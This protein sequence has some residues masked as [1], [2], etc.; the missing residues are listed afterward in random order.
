MKVYAFIII[1][2]LLPLPAY[3]QEEFE[4]I[5]KNQFSILGGLS[6][7]TGDFGE[8]N[9]QKAGFAKTGFG[10]GLELDVPVDES[11][12]VV[13][14]GLFLSNPIDESAMN[15]LFQNAFGSSANVQTESFTSIFALSG[16]QFIGRSSSTSKLFLHA[17]GGL[18]IGTLPEITLTIGS[19][20]STQASAT[21][22]TFAFAVGGGLMFGD[23]FK[24]GAKYLSAKPKYDVT[25]SGTGGTAGGTV[26]QPT[27]MV[28][29]FITIGLSN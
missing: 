3:S 22:T 4:V 10:I 16:I 24:V 14:S 2:V 21:A 12:S 23:R 25:A 29:I 19:A 13:T 17:Q 5:Q 20:Q 26:E 7:P 8:T 11:F 1:F 9:T 28:L 18:L 15:T 27:S 6:L